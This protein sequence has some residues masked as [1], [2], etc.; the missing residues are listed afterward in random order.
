[1]WQITNY[2]ENCD[3]QVKNNFQFLTSIL[4]RFWRGSGTRVIR[5]SG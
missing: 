5:R 1:M 2:C 3:L 4:E